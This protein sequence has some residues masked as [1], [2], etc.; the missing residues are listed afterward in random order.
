M[1]SFLSESTTVKLVNNE[2]LGKLSNTSTKTEIYN[3]YFPGIS[4]KK[5]YDG[6]ENLGKMDKQL[7]PVLMEEYKDYS[8]E[9][10]I[11]YNDLMKQLEGK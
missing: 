5:K 2:R 4:Q 9:V 11:E 10:K 7:R 1:H 3:K 8:Q 6:F